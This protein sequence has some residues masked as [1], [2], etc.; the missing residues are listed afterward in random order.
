[1]KRKQMDIQEFLDV[2]KANEG[3]WKEYDELPDEQK[4]FL[5]HVNI[6]TGVAETYFDDDGELFGVGGIR[7]V[8][9]GESWMVTLPTKRKPFLLRIAAESMKRIVNDKNLWRLFAESKISESFLRHSGFEK[10]DGIY[11]WT[12]T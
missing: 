9:I 4:R 7:Y 11:V 5:A 1:M 10:K 3:I 8:G 6:C 12:R 2:M